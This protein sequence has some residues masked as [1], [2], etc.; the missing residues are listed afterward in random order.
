MQ[1][2]YKYEYSKNYYLCVVKK[3]DYDTKRLFKNY[4]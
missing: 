2:Y 3:K 1:R 4:I